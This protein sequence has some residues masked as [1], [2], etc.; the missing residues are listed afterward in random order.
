VVAAADTQ[1]D[2][3]STWVTLFMPAGNIDDFEGRIYQFSADG[4]NYWLINPNGGTFDGP[5]TIYGTQG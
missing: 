1:T 5:P 2:W 4:S 3:N